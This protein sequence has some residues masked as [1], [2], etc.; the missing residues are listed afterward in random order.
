M[1]GICILDKVLKMG[2]SMIFMDPFRRVG[3]VRPI[4]FKYKLYSKELFMDVAVVK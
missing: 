2:L 1:I 4:G 3:P